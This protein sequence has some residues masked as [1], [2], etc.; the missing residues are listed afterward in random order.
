M[1]RAQYSRLT[2]C[3]RRRGD[4]GIA[5]RVADARNLAARRWF[6]ESAIYLLGV[7]LSGCIGLAGTFLFARLLGPQGYGEYALLLTVTGALSGIL[8]LGGDVVI[9]R[10]WFDSQDPSR[11]GAFA[12]TWIVFLF[13]WSSVAIAAATLIILVPGREL[14]TVPVGL[15]VVACW[16]L[17]PM[18]TGRLLAQVLRNAFRPWAYVFSTV[19]PGAIGLL[20]GLALAG[21]G[22]MGLVGIVLGVAAAS[23][24]ALVIGGGL[25][26]RHLTFRIDWTRVPAALRLGLPL[27]PATLAFWVFSGLDRVFLAS[28]GSVSEL[29]AYALAGQ[30]VAPI[31][32]V[33]TAIM[34]AWLPRA[35]QANETD[36]LLAATSAYR[37]CTIALA[38]FGIGA[39]VASQAATWIIAMVGGPGYEGGRHALPMLA[40]GTSLVSASAFGAAAATLAK[41][42]ALAPVVTVVA[43]LV[44]I[45][46]LLALVPSLGPFG[47]GLAVMVAYAVLFAGSLAYS[48]HVNPAPWSPVQV[49]L[50]VLVLCGQAVVA[51]A[52]PASA[53]AL[54]FGVL[55]LAVAVMV[56]RSQWLEVPAWRT[57]PH[58]SRHQ[59]T[60]NEET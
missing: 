22:Q 48:R 49:V 29:G 56:I 54:S 47:A 57:A 19:A 42:S 26:R 34:Q 5:L 60:G 53:A 31:M 17:V 46:L 6:S 41:R 55:A 4:D 59:P 28:Y 27:V 23:I 44:N 18:Q 39:V 35:Y 25:A 21:P 24:S 33:S 50:L 12:Y 37:A 13:A 52:R 2:S 14:F 1:I 10:F 11:K 36:T 9:G 32:L 43:G 38:T 3:G 45:V 8:L 58:A 20:V 7:L 16:S 40:A 30:V 15:V 51:S